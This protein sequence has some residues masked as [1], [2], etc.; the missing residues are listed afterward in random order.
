MLGLAFAIL[1]V[2]LFCQEQWRL[3]CCDACDADFGFTVLDRP[4][5]EFIAQ[6]ALWWQHK[7]CLG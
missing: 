6:F 5:L 1:N 2:S 4:F 3:V 7:C